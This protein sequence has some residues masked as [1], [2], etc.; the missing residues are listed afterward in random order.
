V[1]SWL[2]LDLSGSKERWQSLL[3]QSLELD[4]GQTCLLVD[5]TSPPAGRDRH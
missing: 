4:F 5:Y 2:N 3:Y 1:Q